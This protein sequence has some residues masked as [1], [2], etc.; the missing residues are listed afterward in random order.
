[1]GRTA[2]E[3]Q[4]LPPGRLLRAG[5]R[6]FQFLGKAASPLLNWKNP[7]TYWD[8]ATGT[9]LAIL[10]GEPLWLHRFMPDQTRKPIV[11]TDLDGT[12]LDHHTYGYD[13]VLPLLEKLKKAG[14]PVV[15]NTS[16]TRSEWLHL[17]QEIGND[18]PFVVE[19]GSAIYLPDGECVVF[20]ERREE[21]L[22]YLSGL[23]SRYNF[24]SYSGW[25][26]EDIAAATGLDLDS[27]K[28]SS[29]REFSEPT[30]WKGSEEEKINFIEEV[31]TAGF[32]TLQGG[33]FLHILG[34]TDKGK[35]LNWFRQQSPEFSPV[36]ALGDGPNDI[37]MLQAADI[38][39][40]IASP[41][42]R[43]IHFE[44][45]HR[46]IRSTLEGPEGWAETMNPL[47]DT[48]LTD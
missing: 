34:R 10:F 44:S 48:F 18:D 38:G 39:I 27:A 33:R 8:E 47:L 22:G 12:L 20:G 1:M 31:R 29:E 36:I 6:S 37:A 43:E 14:V 17:A 42:G 30:V 41:T 2:Q 24:E 21:I 35:A 4:A 7:S 3:G 11:F 45:D 16:K 13:P 32:T 23:K 28:R 25:T 19:N 5:K 9:H 40:V 26:V 46:I 15:A